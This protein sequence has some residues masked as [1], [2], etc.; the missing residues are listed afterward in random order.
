[1]QIDYV[2]GQKSSSLIMEIEDNILRMLVDTGAAA[3]MIDIGIAKTIGVYNKINTDNAKLYH[4]NSYSNT[5]LNVIGDVTIHFTFDGV[6]YPINA[7]VVSGASKHPILGKDFIESY[8]TTLQAI[9]GI[10]SMSVNGGENIYAISNSKSE[11]HF[12]ALNAVSAPHDNAIDHEFLETYKTS[13]FVSSI[14]PT[15]REFVNFI[16][17]KKDIDAS[18]FFTDEWKEEKLNQ[19]KNFTVADVSPVVIKVKEGSQLP[20]SSP[21]KLTPEK[22]EASQTA[23]SSTK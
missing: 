3:T 12:T 4:F 21:Y 14:L 8:N 10:W 6:K 18:K 13:G 23:K 19:Q 17:I 9:N 11:T 2:A 7:I 15:H 1:M 20:K 22:E 16:A 5:K